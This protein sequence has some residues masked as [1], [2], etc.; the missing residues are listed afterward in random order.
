MDADAAQ[1]WQ[2]TAIAAFYRAEARGF[3][4]GAELD[5]WLAAERELDGAGVTHSPDAIAQAPR[6]V[7]A[8]RSQ[9]PA[10]AGG[11]PVK[12]AARGSRPV[13][14]RAGAGEQA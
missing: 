14:A 8:V 7:D 3:A 6:P 12:R 11:S 9:A 10:A 13:R 2:R 5:D 4:P 1:R